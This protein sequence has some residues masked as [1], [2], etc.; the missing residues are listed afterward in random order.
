MEAL[1]NRE[2]LGA[3]GQSSPQP[4]LKAEGH[5]AIAGAEAT[6]AHL[7]GI[8]VLRFPYALAIR[9]LIEKDQVASARQLLAIALLSEP[10]EPSLIRLQGVLAPPRVSR[11]PGTGVPRDG[12]YRWLSRHADEYR[13]QWVAVMGD[14]LIAHSP[15]L[16]DLLTVVKT[17]A[18]GQTPLVYRFEDSDAGA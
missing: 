2:I 12:E 9:R 18:P 5:R 16:K 4:S 7:S 3:L 6:G 13:G 14:Q 15:H 8:Q 11:R 1:L 17:A 10:S